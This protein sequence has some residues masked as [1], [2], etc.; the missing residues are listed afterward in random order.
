MASAS[1]TTTRW[2]T[3]LRPRCVQSTSCRVAAPMGNV[4]MNPANVSVT[5]RITRAVRLGHE[6]AF[7]E[8]VKAWVPTALAF[9][10]HL[11]VN[12]LRPMPGNREYVAVVKFRSQREWEAFLHSPQYQD[13][14]AQIRPLLEAEPRVET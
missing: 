10:G 4:A 11:G 14:P 3:A 7:E 9:P 12:M 6:A 5:V 8:A 2:C 13:F 1:N